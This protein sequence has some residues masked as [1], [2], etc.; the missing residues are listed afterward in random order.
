[1]E[2]GEAA[3]EGDR[4]RVGLPAARPVE[5]VEDPGGA[6]KQQRRRH[7][8]DERERDRY[9]PGFAGHHAQKNIIETHGYE[10]DSRRAPFEPLAPCA[11]T[12]RF[13]RWTTAPSSS[14]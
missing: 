7:A 13:A 10:Q 2:D 6:G 4:M 12:L 11:L 14:T 3:D 8:R 1:D 9:Q 5:K